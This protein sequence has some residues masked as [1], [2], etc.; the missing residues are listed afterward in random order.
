[1]AKSPASILFSTNGLEM[2]VGSGIAIPAN[3]RGLL[4]AGTDGTNARF[5]KVATDGTQVVKTENL[6]STNNSTSATLAGGL[7][8]TGTADEVT[9]F[10]TITILVKADQAGTLS[11]QFSPDGTNWDDQDNYSIPANTGKFYTLPV[12]ARYFRIVYTNGGTAQTSFRLQTKFHRVALKPSSHR[13][14]DTITDE[15]D[16]ELQKSVIAGRKPDGTYVNASFDDQGRLITAPP[17]ATSSSAGFAAGSV[18]TAAINT[19][20]VRDTTYTEQTT[21]AQRQLLSANAADA[22][23]GTGARKVKITYYKADY[24]GPFTEEVTL[25]GVTA[26]NTVATDICFIEKM[27]VT[28]V[29]SG[30]SNAGIITLRTLASVTIGTIAVGN[31]RT[32]WAHHYVPPSKT[33]N[34]TSFYMAG[35]NNAST[36]TL[37]SR[38][39]T[40]NAPEVV[41]SD[42]VSLYGASNAFLRTYSTPIQVAGPARITAYIQTTI[43]TSTTNRASFDFYEE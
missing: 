3:T 34:I 32:Y 8:F 18:V 41:V 16:V 33:C 7:A 13:L 43:S 37:R 19:F 42:L 26:V 10:S 29:G 1:M 40:A 23:A 14:A 21:G 36:F 28:E 38:P 5:L 17:G 24:T 30:G 20:A 31:N 9:D 39:S 35:S 12:E 11:C 27:E 15:D 4:M 22:A 25:N 6:I 2:A